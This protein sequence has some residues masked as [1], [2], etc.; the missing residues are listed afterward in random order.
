MS[1]H[2]VAIG[3]I[4]LRLWNGAAQNGLE[5]DIQV[6]R[7]ESVNILLEALCDREI[8]R[9]YSDPVIGFCCALGHQEHVGYFLVDKVVVALDVLFIDVQ[10]RG[11][12]KKVLNLVRALH[13]LVRLYVMNWL[14]WT[15]SLHGDFPQEWERP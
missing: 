11:R 6:E 1:F 3:K 13:M 10:A 15:W 7:L 8:A 5:A 14:K 2:F 12:T 9:F 4:E